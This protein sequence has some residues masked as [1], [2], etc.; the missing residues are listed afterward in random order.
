[1]DE[2]PNLLD[3]SKLRYDLEHRDLF[4]FLALHRPQGL[5]CPICGTNH[6]GVY[7]TEDS[8]VRRTQGRR[9]YRVLPDGRK[10][11]DKFNPDVPSEM[12]IKY[13]QDCYSLVCSKCGHLVSF[14]ASVV[15]RSAQAKRAL[16]A[17]NKKT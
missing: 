4:D 16:E 8:E 6:W 12:A 3:P 1:M 14:N 5:D 9:E 13:S 17:R 10:T 7:V 2:E 15:A 11:V